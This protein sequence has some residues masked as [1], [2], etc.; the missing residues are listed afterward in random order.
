MTID[1]FWKKYDHCPKCK[2]YAIQGNRCYGCM[3]RT[4]YPKETDF[5]LFEP[6]EDC[7]RAINRE[8]TEW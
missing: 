5:D 7:I 3:W 8:V 2:G 4:P 6:T 1:D